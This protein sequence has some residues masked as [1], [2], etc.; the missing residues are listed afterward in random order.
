MIM[1]ELPDRRSV[2]HRAALAGGIRVVE[3]E[4][5]EPLVGELFRRRFK[6]DTFPPSPIHFVEVFERPDGDS[7]P[8]GY[9]HAT[10]WEGGA[11]G[12]GMV[13]DEFRYRILPPTLRQQVREAGGLTEILLREFITLLPPG[14]PAVWGCVG[15]RRAER[16]DLRVGFEHT[17][18]PH[19]IVYWLR[20]D[21]PLE[22][23]AEW[24]RRAAALGPF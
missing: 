4:D 2:A 10:M 8:I 23:K 14:T 3:T 22:E 11:L 15:D 21:M 19:L 18:V 12:G 24:I 7:I 13:I 20:T 5:A 17:G 9:I 6:T 16:V 1:D